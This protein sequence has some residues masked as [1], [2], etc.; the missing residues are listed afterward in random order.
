MKRIYKKICLL[1]L[2]LTLIFT[3]TPFAMAETPV[4]DYDTSWA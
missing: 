3:L 4:H 2:S 1:I